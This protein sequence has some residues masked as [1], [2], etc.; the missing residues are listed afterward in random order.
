MVKLLD[1]F[2]T[3]LLMKK[4]LALCSFL[5]FS[6]APYAEEGYILDCKDDSLLFP[7]QQFSTD[8]DNLTITANHSEIDQNN[9]YL[10][11]GDVS[12]VS[13]KFYV[14]ADE[15][16]LNKTNKSSS[17]TGDVRFQNDELMFTS[18][19]AVLVQKGDIIS[20]TLD[21]IKFHY[22]NLRINGTA[23]KLS[24][25][26]IE[27][28]F[29]KV[30]YT[31]CPLG[32]T[33]WVM[34]ADKITLNAKTHIGN[35]KNVRVEFL[36]IPIFYLEDYEWV[37]KGRNSGYLSPSFGSYEANGNNAMQIRIPYYF[38]IAPDRDFLLTLNQLSSR[39]SVLEGKYRQLIDEHP[40]LGSGD[41]VVEGHLLDR[42]KI[43][44]KKRWLLNTDISMDINDKLKLDL[45]TR[46]V[47][48]VDYFKEIVHSNTAISALQSYVNLAYTDTENALDMA[49]FSETEQNINTDTVAETYYKRASEVSL[50]K[51]FEG[52]NNRSI[53]LS[54]VSTKFTHKTLTDTGV[55]THGQVVFN[56]NIKTPAY[57]LHPK[58]TLS[59]TNYTM[60]NSAN[61]A[62]KIGSFS[63]DS[64][65]FLERDTEF[66][67]TQ[68]TQT[69]TPRFAYHY[70]PSVDQ[71]AL[72]KFDSEDK[73]DSYEG[74]FSSRKFTGL[75]RFAAA[76][77]VVIGVESEFVDGDTGDTYLKLKMAQAYYD[78]KQDIRRT[79]NEPDDDR[80]YSDIATEI[81]LTLDKLSFNN[82]LQV[83]PE[84]HEIYKRDTSMTYLLNG[85][86]FIS[87]SHDNFIDG[88]GERQKNA[89]LYGSLP[90]DSKVHVF[91]GINRSLTNH[92]N[93][94]ETVGAVY[95]T[96][97]W[98][99]RVAHFKEHIDEDKYD[100]IS[101]F[102][103]VLKGLSSTSPSLY[104]DIEEDIPNYLADLDNF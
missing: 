98:A 22:P 21:N 2:E 6:S 48:D 39:G 104:K 43:T 44:L 16:T 42:D 12:L 101:H 49:I 86:K 32:N 52:L 85:R 65:L 81:D 91:A 77:D 24:D 17:S 35:A 1:F 68:L 99:V 97:C 23:A 64:K 31:L 14:S 50:N 56:R 4:R 57:L 25:N 28:T 83:D 70:T 93:N 9:R 27:Q 13:N 33:D 78:E 89:R 79:E 80:H 82:V 45:V 20:T 55:R 40:F 95:E 87:L 5:L 26:K 60:D 29:D 34:K 58:L 71:E 8:P 41:I 51:Q 38:N 15:I 96:C 47:S 67:D 3:E 62:R 11:S 7:K 84:N 63:L 76:N 30:T 75:D 37:I 19:D 59:H 103:L 10:L 100:H 74:L 69:L 90:L 72:P 53:D 18:D 92:L 54:L 102:E 73:N 88:D 66:F 36:G 61:Q 46:R 94:K